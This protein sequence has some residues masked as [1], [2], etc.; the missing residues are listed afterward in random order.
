MHAVVTGG[1]GFLGR[2]IVA[3]L[4]NRGDDVKVIVHQRRPGVA[5]PAVVVADVRDAAA[6]RTAFAGADVIYHA[7]GK[8]GFWGAREAFW[9]VNVEG[10]KAVLAAARACGVPRL[11]YTST[12]SVVGYAR[13]VENGGPDLPYPAAHENAYG[14]TKCVAEQLVLAA[15]APGFATVALRPHVLIGPGDERMLPVVLRRAAQGRLRVIGNGANKIDLTYVDNAAWAHLDAADALASTGAPCAGRPYFITNGQPVLLWQWLNALLNELD[16][17][18]VTASLR[19]GTARL[20]GLVSETVWKTLGV[21]SDPP[22]TRALAT[23]LA[24][25]H[26]YDLEPAR[27]DLG[28]RVRVPMDEANRRTASWLAERYW[29]A[30]RRAKRVTAPRRSAHRGERPDYY[31]AP[32]HDFTQYTKDYEAKY[33]SQDTAFDWQQSVPDNLKAHLDR[34]EPR[35]FARLARLALPLVYQALSQRIADIRRYGLPS[36]VDA[37]KAVAECIPSDRPAIGDALAL[38][39]PLEQ[40]AVPLHRMADRLAILTRQLAELREQQRVGL[41][42][43]GTEVRRRT[44]ATEAREQSEQLDALVAQVRQAERDLG[45]ARARTNAE[46]VRLEASIRAQL[47]AVEPLVLVDL[48][49]TRT[50]VRDALQAL[51]SDTRTLVRLRDLVWKRQ[52]RGLKDIA[53]H[54]L[55]VEQSAIAPLTMGV[56]HYKRRREIQQAMT[57]FVNDEAKHSAVFRRFMAQKLEAKEHIPDAII[58]GS[59]RYMWLARFMPSG[60]VFLANIVE[61]IGAAFLEFFGKAENMPDPLFR[62]ICRTIAGRDEQRHMDLCAA[63]YNELY[64]TGSRWERLRNRAALR[65]MMKAAYGDK[66]EDHGLL[67]ACRAFGIDSSLPYRHVAGCLSAQ[68]QRIGMYVPPEQLLGF[69]QLQRTTASADR[70]EDGDRAGSA[71]PQP[72]TR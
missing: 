24:R 37:L 20:A 67:Q 52:L 53:N 47:D 68:L 32:T 62:S 40:L 25:S 57:T 72:P 15:N 16:L 70:A 66:N 46:R 60:G 21:S 50:L 22:L 59:E 34:L 11:V 17:P 58:K 63:T 26:W 45:E 38:L 54:A 69:M 12:P 71:P 31:I 4:R 43:S 13:D 2:R 23:V 33:W 19:F 61:A 6:L 41:F 51:P 29:T 49:D 28:Y 10:T 35:E 39:A 27:R 42:K 30:E 1:E 56:I 64:R 36:D 48:D 9:S 5:D 55:V 44:T 3:L 14:E 18:E 65:V 7:A 8:V